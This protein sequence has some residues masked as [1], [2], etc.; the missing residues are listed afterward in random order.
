MISPYKVSFRL[1]LVTQ[2]RRLLTVEHLEADD[3]VLFEGIRV[4]HTNVVLVTHTLGGND[5]ADQLGI[6]IK[7][8]EHWQGKS[9]GSLDESTVFG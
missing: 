9:L 4:K 6:G 7:S 8:Q 5:C 1:D 2:S 3:C